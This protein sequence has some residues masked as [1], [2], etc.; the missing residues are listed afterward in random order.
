MEMPA[1][2]T[3]ALI[4]GPVFVIVLA[5]CVALLVRFSSLKGWIGVA[6]VVIGIIEV[7]LVPV[8][9]LWVFLIG[10]S[11]LI[12]GITMFANALL[13]NRERA[14]IGIVAI[15]IGILG[16][17]ILTRDLFGFAVWLATLIFGIAGAA[18]LLPEQ[19][20]AKIGLVSAAVG[21]VVILISMYTNFLALAFFV[22]LE[23]MFSGIS[24]GVS[25]LP[26][27]AQRHSGGN[28][29]R[30]LKKILYGLLVFVIFSSA[31]VFS[32][33]TTGALREE[34]FDDWSYKTTA[35]TTVRGVVTEIF[36]NYEVN[37]HGYSYHIF[38]A[39]MIVNVSEV[40]KAARASAGETWSNLTEANEYWVNQN[41]TV[42]YDKPDIPS[43]TVG[44]RVEASG[45]FDM[46]IEDTWS[47]SY[48]LVIAAEIDDSYVLPL[49]G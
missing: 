28:T 22:G 43:V 10:L 42:A 2:Y 17:L 1:I 12:I 21:F 26:Y 46:P 7:T 48:K 37:N 19:R 31:L 5:L 36:L 13:S 40:L 38:P 23:V 47:Y 8:W 35:D 45:Y 6:M 34:L 18:A 4:F 15:V 32:L 11:T 16:I 44:Q 20:R 49:Q 29:I 33:R 27:W 41:M 14:G 3:S 25:G 30:S 24:V 9:V 39:L